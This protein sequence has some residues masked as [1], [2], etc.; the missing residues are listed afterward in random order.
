VTFTSPDLR[1]GVKFGSAK[2]NNRPKQACT[3]TLGKL[4]KPTIIKE[5]Y[6]STNEVM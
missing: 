1:G 6:L 4:K 2:D 5:F 3:H